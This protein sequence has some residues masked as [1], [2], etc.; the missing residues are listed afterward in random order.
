MIGFERGRSPKEALGI[1]A[2]EFTPIKVDP[3]EHYNF[4][5]LIGDELLV[6]RIILMGELKYKG[7][8]IIPQSVMFG[9]LTHNIIVLSTEGCPG[10]ILDRYETFKF[11]E[12][13]QLVTI[14]SSFNSK[15]DRYSY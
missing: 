9:I 13:L 12:K 1:G 10:I 15:V 6:K 14:S 11:L 8:R 5:K 3:M 4:D 7:S 2:G